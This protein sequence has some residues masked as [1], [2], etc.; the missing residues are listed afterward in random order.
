MTGIPC[1]VC[2]RGLRDPASAARRIGPVCARKLH[3]TPSAVV[4]GQALEDTGQ[5]AI[6]TEEQHAQH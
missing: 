1:D 3:P 2:G 5:L 6:D 4:D